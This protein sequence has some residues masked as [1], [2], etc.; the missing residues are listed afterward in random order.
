MG[1][2]CPTKVNARIQQE[3]DQ[4][5]GR[6]SCCSQSKTWLLAFLLGLC[7]LAEAEVMQ[8]KAGRSLRSTSP[9]FSLDRLRKTSG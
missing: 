4:S 9:D 3:I 6:A 5:K 1:E 8:G 2:G 7:W